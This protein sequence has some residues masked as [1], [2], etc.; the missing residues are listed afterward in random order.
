PPE[1]L[2]LIKNSLATEREPDVYIDGMLYILKEPEFADLDKVSSLMAMFDRPETVRSIMAP[3][4]AATAVR[5]T[6]GAENPVRDVR[7]CTV[8]TTGYSSGA[9]AHGAIGIVAPR[10]MDYE[11]A[12]SAVGH[13][14]QRLGETVTRMIDD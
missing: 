1:V 3:P 14:A 2:Q 11:S 7:D 8:I 5:V 12:I 9:G 4:D 10:R 13:V 6:I